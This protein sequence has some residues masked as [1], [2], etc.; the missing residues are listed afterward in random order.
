MFITFGFACCICCFFFLLPF[1][2]CFYFSFFTELVCFFG[3]WYSLSEQTNQYFFY[4]HK[5]KRLNKVSRECTFEKLSIYLSIFEFA[6]AEVGPS[7]QD[8]GPAIYNFRILW[9]H[10]WTTSWKYLVQIDAS[11]LAQ[12]WFYRN[13]SYFGY[14]CWTLRGK[15]WIR[16]KVHLKR[17]QIQKGAKYKLFLLFVFSGL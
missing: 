14:F 8:G 15:L 11:N 4:F 9:D 6:Q 13:E 7:R 2:T 17:N 1:P 12:F 10:G 5:W 16:L 3:Y